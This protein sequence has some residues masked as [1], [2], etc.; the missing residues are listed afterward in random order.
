MFLCSYV[1]ADNDFAGKERH[2]LQDKGSN[3]QPLNRQGVWWSIADFLVSMDQSCSVCYVAK[4]CKERLSY[5]VLT[6]HS[7]MSVS[8][9]PF[10]A[11][12]CLQISTNYQYICSHSHSLRGW[13]ISHF[14]SLS[15]YCWQ[16]ERIL[17]STKNDTRDSWMS[18]ACC[19]TISHPKLLEWKKCIAVHLEAK[20]II[21]C[22]INNCE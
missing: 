6:M 19:L 16:L 10:E 18:L 2:C 3:F 7:L 5:I 11:Q 1:A 12:D 14:S 15:T 4:V 17:W 22:A 9:V 21:A 20:S 8:L 13:C